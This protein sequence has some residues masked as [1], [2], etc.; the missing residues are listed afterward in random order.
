MAESPAAIPQ[1]RT[2]S[3]EGEMAVLDQTETGTATRMSHLTVAYDA[4]RT[5]TKTKHKCC[6][7][8]IQL[9]Q[10]IRHCRL[11]IR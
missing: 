2:V 4:D 8:N 3:I 1:D 9:E 10:G 5:K 6:L 11:G 7:R